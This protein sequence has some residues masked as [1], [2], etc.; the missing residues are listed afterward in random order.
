MTKDQNSEKCIGIVDW[1][2][3]E[4][5]NAPYGFIKSEKYGDVF[6]HQ[7]ALIHGL[8]SL[9]DGQVVIFSPTPSRRKPGKTDASDVYLLTDENNLV[10][11]LNQYFSKDCCLSLKIHE[12]IYYQ[13]THSISTNPE[14]SNIDDARLLC[15]KL[16][17]DWIV[18]K[19]KSAPLINYSV[20]QN[21]INLVICV[22]ENDATT[23]FDSLI[24]YFDDLS[25][26]KL[27]LDGLTKEIHRKTLLNIFISSNLD[28]K[29]HILSKI[30]DSNKKTLIIEW[31]NGIL[32]D[33]PSNLVS[34]LEIILRLSNKYLSDDF[35][36]LIS[37]IKNRID[38]SILFELWLLKIIGS[39]YPEIMSFI[40]KMFPA[41]NSHK[42][43]QVFGNCNDEDITPL[44]LQLIQ[45]LEKIYNQREY[46][47]ACSLLKLTEDYLPVRY[48]QFSSIFFEAA[49]PQFQLK[50]WIDNFPLKINIK[51]Y[52]K[53]IIYLSEEDQIELIKK[54]FFLV[55]IGKLDMSDTLLESIISL[56]QNLS[57]EYCVQ[58]NSYNLSRSVHIVLQ[59]ILSLK[60]TGSVPKQNKLYDIIIDRISSADE[61]LMIKGFFERCNGRAVPII[62][63]NSDS[64]EIAGDI[65]FHKN[66]YIFEYCEGRLA[67]NK[68]HDNQVLLDN[69]YKLQY[70][71]CGNQKCF[72]ACQDLH[73]DKD[74]KQ[75]TLRDFL[76][77]LNISYDHK[78]YLT[79]IG[80]INKTNK[81]L[82]HLNCRECNNIL[83]PAKITNYAFWR[84]NHFKCTNEKCSLHNNDVYLTHCINGKCN[85]VVD[86]RNCVKC[87]PDNFETSNC[88]WYICNEC[89]ACCSSEK[90]NKRKYVMELTGQQYSCHEVGH[91][92]L[93]QICC[94]KCGYKMVNSIIDYIKAKDWFNQ[95]KDDRNVIVKFGKR[96]DGGMWYL[97]K[98]TTSIRNQEYI[99]YLRYLEQIGFSI[100]EID[101]HKDI[102]LVGESFQGSDPE[103]KCTNCG[104]SLNILKIWNERD[105]GTLNVLKY[106]EPI[107]EICESLKLKKAVFDTR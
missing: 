69:Y 49:S 102:H 5:R 80:M 6:V 74:W 105:F 100:P 33:P 104:H 57:K 16:F 62:A 39:L 90:I 70:W 44:L 27:Y 87:I 67:T 85:N 52:L 14:K 22:M 97:Y 23:V 28:D 98:R 58:P 59:T 76:E 65:K 21:V 78:Q 55:H 68:Q 43:K 34:I 92:D 41:W 46:E 83:H 79:F 11:L 9:R 7:K 51:E 4:I 48:Q 91:E 103:F 72:K 1:F 95:N 24:Q 73:L 26:V 2:Y 84:V 18:D 86:S 31:L 77:I 45:S 93:K 50:F 54:M 66:E 10:F 81:F 12:H 19:S 3:D 60:Q 35:E 96:N 8:E 99:Q 42:Q 40:F 30:P 38:P 106:H 25:K 36:E 61:I 53:Y 107:Y 56:K 71:W 75:Y 82:K 20:N 15:Q 32:L 17:T 64:K 88:G 29:D 89:Y 101:E 13:I 37:Q 47:Y 94:K 63:H